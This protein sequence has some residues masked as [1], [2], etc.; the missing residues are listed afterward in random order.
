MPADE[1]IEMRL[2]Q[3]ERTHIDNMAAAMYTERVA[4]DAKKGRAE[5]FGKNPDARQLYM[6][7]VHDMITCMN[8]WI[9]EEIDPELLN[10]FVTA[11]HDQTCEDVN[12]GNTH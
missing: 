11:L 7:G 1:G 9:E 5:I 12:S 8:T 3:E 6:K 4:D 2:S 10:V